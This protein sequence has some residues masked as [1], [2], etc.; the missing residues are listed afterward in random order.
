[1]NTQK[2]IKNKFIA[3]FIN[4]V[5]DFIEIN[6]IEIDKDKILNYQYGLIY[7]KNFFYEILY[8]MYD[9][10]FIDEDDYKQIYNETTEFDILLIYSSEQYKKFTN[11]VPPS[12]ISYRPN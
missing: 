1:M 5:I 10:Q 9:K 3:N 2:N 6:N 4:N 11:I 7:F 12:I 8:E